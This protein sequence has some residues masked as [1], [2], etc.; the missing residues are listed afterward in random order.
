LVGTGIDGVLINGISAGGET[1]DDI[2]V[3]LVDIFHHLLEHRAVIVSGRVAGL[4]VGLANDP[5]LG[6]AMGR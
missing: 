4:D 2:E 3:A 1:H 5:A 6:F